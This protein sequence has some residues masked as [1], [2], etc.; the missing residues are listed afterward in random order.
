MEAP[1]TVYAESL[2]LARLLKGEVVR[3]PRR[4]C[5]NFSRWKCGRDNL[6]DLRVLFSTLTRSERGVP[7]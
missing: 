4:P 1:G 7:S 3:V 6:P 2:A 5:M